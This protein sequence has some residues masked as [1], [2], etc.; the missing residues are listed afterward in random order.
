MKQ[1][2][3]ILVARL[4]QGTI[5]RQELAERGCVAALG[6]FEG[7][8]C[9][10]VIHRTVRMTSFELQSANPFANLA[11][12]RGERIISLLGQENGVF[13]LWLFW[14]VVDPERELRMRDT[15]VGGHIEVAVFAQS[16]EQVCKLF[17]IRE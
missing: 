10:G 17:V 5:L 8:S 6:R 16:L 12:R 15:K 7:C 3:T 11:E 2:R 1:G 13:A 4:E 9:V 14:L